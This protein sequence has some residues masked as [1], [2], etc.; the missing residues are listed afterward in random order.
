[1]P[2]IVKKQPT[3][4]LLRQRGQLKEE[5]DGGGKEGRKIRRDDSKK[6]GEQL[7]GS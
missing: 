5:K 3:R 7:K 2:Y 1:L 6:Q 4:H